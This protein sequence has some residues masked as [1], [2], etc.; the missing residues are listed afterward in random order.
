ME[1]FQ[2]I[3]NAL[4][5]ENEFF[6]KLN[7]IP[8]IFL[9]A[10][11]YMLMFLTLLKIESTKKQQI[12]FVVV[13]SII[14]IF[15]TFFGIA[16]YN[17]LVNVL[18]MPVLVL[19]IFKTS[20]LKA[21]LSQVI[22][23][24]IVVLVSTISITIYST[25]LQVP[26]SASLTVPI[27]KICISL[28][29]YLS[30]YTI[31]K[32]CKKFNINISLLDKLKKRITFLL[33]LNFVIGTIAIGTEYYLLFKYIDLIPN[34]LVFF[35]LFVLSLYFGI[36]LYSLLRTNKLEITAQ[37]LE[38]QKMYNK[39]LNT[40]YDNIRGFKHDF[41]NIVQAIGGYL[42]ADNLEGLR[43]YYKD[44]LEECQINN[45]LAVL[46]PELINNPAIYSLLA[47]KYYK[48]EKASIKLNLEVMADLSNL[49]IKVYELSRILGVLL[50][51]S[52]EAAAKCENKLVNVIFRNDKK[53]NKVLIIIQNTYINKNINIDRIFEKGYSSKKDDTSNQKHGL[54]LWEIKKYLEKNTNL[55]L[56]TTKND[57][58]FTQQFEI[59]N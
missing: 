22:V 23:F 48:A 54:G 31:Y 10:C 8:S 43:A 18:A 51:N 59:Y 33:V 19:L 12:I 20:V 2:T 56:Y 32:L 55:D 52:L 30:L 57:E 25:I 24:I 15:N 28:L 26:S 53:H 17:N 50:D 44:L 36:S 14:S 21:V 34:A 38:D 58:F 4:I 1:I 46:N 7:A 3:W 40:L 11:L 9:E 49:N 41:N 45:N 35:S 27:H 13:F 47:D 29:L 37:S 42:S 6:I 39:T 5:S 16:P